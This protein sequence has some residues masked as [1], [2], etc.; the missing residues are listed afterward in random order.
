LCCCCC[1][2]CLCCC[3]CCSF[4]RSVVCHCWQGSSDT[5]G[6]R[7]QRGALCYNYIYNSFGCCN[8]IASQSD[9]V[10]HHSALYFVINPNLISYCDI[11]WISCYAAVVIIIIPLSHNINAID[12]APLQR[13]YAAVA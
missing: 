4:L 12:P 8:T 5:S 10:T 11:H 2:C 1:C 9:V 6:S 3:C 13:G 7:R